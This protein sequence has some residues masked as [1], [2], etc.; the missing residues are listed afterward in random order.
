MKTQRNSNATEAVPKA[1][2]SEPLDQKS[3]IGK[4][5]PETL[6]GEN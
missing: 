2:C 4:F 3:Q 1:N 6:E 5:P